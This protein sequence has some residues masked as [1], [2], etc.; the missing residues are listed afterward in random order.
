MKKV[1]NKLLCI[2]YDCCRNCLFN[3]NCKT[4][5]SEECSNDGQYIMTV[6]KMSH[7]YV[8]DEKSSE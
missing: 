7:I 6:Y 5:Q 1:L 2:D 4:S 8:D 3:S